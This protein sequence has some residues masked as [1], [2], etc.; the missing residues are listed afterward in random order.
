[1]IIDF[2]SLGNQATMHIVVKIAQNVAFE[3][4][5]FPPIFILLI[6]TCLVTLFD[7]KLKGFQKL[8]TMDNFWRFWLTFVRSKC[9]AR[10]A[11]NVEWDFFCDFQTPCLGFDIYLW[12]HVWLWSLRI[13]H[14]RNRRSLPCLFDLQLWLSIVRWLIPHETQP[15]WKKIQKDILI[16][17]NVV[18]C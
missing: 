7:L 2:C 3:F 14:L 12:W 11:R 8:A 13:L 16:A 4:W 15:N 5:H 6:L 18:V 9:V 17:S 1:M 10:F